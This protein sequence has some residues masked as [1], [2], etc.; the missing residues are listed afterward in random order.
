MRS[1]SPA[2]NSCTFYPDGFEMTR[3]FTVRLDTPSE[4]PYEVLTTEL[5]DKAVYYVKTDWGLLDFNSFVHM[6]DPDQMQQIYN[7]YS[8][9]QP[10]EWGIM[11]DGIKVQTLQQ[12][13]GE[14]LASADLLGTV[15][16]AVRER[17]TMPWKQWGGGTALCDDT[18][19]W[20]C[21]LTHKYWETVT[22]PQYGYICPLDRPGIK[23][24][25]LMERGE[26]I[27]LTATDSVPMGGPIYCHNSVGQTVMMGNLTDPVT[28]H[29]TTVAEFVEVAGSKFNGALPFDPVS[30]DL[31]DYTWTVASNGRQRMQRTTA[32]SSTGTATAPGSGY[33]RQEAA[34]T[35][36]TFIGGDA[37]A[38]P[39][40]AG[41]GT[42]VFNNWATAIDNFQFSNTPYSHCPA[43]I[44]VIKPWDCSTHRSRY[45]AP[46]AE[47]AP[48]QIFIRLKKV[49]V[50]PKR[51]LVQ[52]ATLQVKVH[53]KWR[54]T[55]HRKNFSSTACQRVMD[56]D[57][58]PNYWN[59]DT[60]L[61]VNPTLQA[62]YTN[63]YG[64][65]HHFY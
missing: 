26:I 20:H 15:E 60:P 8:T 28:N 3:T 6:F 56:Y 42:G 59:W 17:G 37:A 9:W 13:G 63:A 45:G 50:A 29:P 27:R 31:G 32:M 14:E 10:C 21:W 5:T 4:E 1:I 57:Y 18:H 43:P 23:S 30:N 64:N 35:L 49:E 65:V 54:A 41:T 25:F 34:D 48:P 19:A 46:V 55:P 24:P 53:Y 44:Y 40:V 51:H 7:R 33:N 58:Q 11:I 47:K 52:T 2:V 38:T 16:M 62:P 12:I 22:P 61:T 39:S 36:S